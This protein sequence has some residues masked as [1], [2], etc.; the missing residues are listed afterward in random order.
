MKD[1][2]VS[3]VSFNDIDKLLVEIGKH[4]V[5]VTKKEAD[6]NAGIQKIK[7]KY[8]TETLEARTRIEELEAKIEALSTSI[9]TEFDSKRTKPLTHGK[10]G[11]R[12][13]TP[14]VLQLNKKYKVAT[15][16]EL[17]KQL[18][19]KRFVRSKDELNK[20]AI[21]AE[22]NQKK[23]TDEQ[24]A[25]MGLRIDQDEKFFYEIDWEKLDN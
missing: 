9:K 8:D 13:G 18:F 16:I 17:A 24:V 22:H 14:K 7:E 3:S 2:N 10:V 11:F 6:M 25:A 23:I 15:S 12:T 1:G 20:E 19:K 21:I 4:K 5:V